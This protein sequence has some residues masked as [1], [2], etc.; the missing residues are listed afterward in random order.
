LEIHD[1]KGKNIVTKA[2]SLPVT[3]SGSG[4]AYSQLPCIAL[5]ANWP[6]S[7]RGWPRRPG[8]KQPLLRGHGLKIAKA[9]TKFSIAMP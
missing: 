4:M 5:S 9:S 8:A 3:L 7:G 6:N 2:L 1:D